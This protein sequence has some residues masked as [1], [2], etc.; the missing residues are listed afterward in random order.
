[1]SGAPSAPAASCQHRWSN[2]R[3]GLAI[4]NVSVVGAG[5]PAANTDARA[6]FSARGSDLAV[7]RYPGTLELGRRHSESDFNFGVHRRKDLAG[8]T[9][10]TSTAVSIARRARAVQA[11]D[12]DAA[13]S[14]NVDAGAAFELEPPAPRGYAGRGF[15]CRR[16]ACRTRQLQAADASRAALARPTPFR[17]AEVCNHGLMT[18]GHST[19]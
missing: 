14:A 3:C 9:G 5:S 16:R 19:H 2:A 17:V 12:V 11:N 10:T 8:L 18:V 1:M 4:Q 7:G 6:I 13:A 15:E